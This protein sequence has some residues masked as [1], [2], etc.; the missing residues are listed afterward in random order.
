M[1][2][3]K[4]N[5]LGE[6]DQNVELLGTIVQTFEP[7]F[8][9]ICPQCGKRA[10]QKEG[11]F[12]CKQH[13]AVEPAYSYVFNV[14]LDDGTDSIRCAFFRQQADTLTGKTSEQMLAYRESPEK[15]EEVKNELLGNI[16]KVSGRVRKNEMFDRME[17]N[18]QN[19]DPNPDPQKEI[20]RMKQ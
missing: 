10:M 2:R 18:A 14:S 5:E 3:K 9:E 7:R 16:I 11:K 1:Q 12:Y 20:D 8:F 17:F 15:F 6:S 13:E 4:I 19:V